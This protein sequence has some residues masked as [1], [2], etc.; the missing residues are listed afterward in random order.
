MLV[1]QNI[2]RAFDEYSEEV[3]RTGNTSRLE[4]LHLQ[5]VGAK[6]YSTNIASR[7]V[8]TCRIAC[9]GHGYSALAG[10]GRMYAHTV[11][12]VTYEGDNYVIAQQVPRAIFKHYNA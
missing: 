1:G 11:N 12:A 8:E 6:V 7:G 3:I 10:F 4:D 9:G 5:T 2:K